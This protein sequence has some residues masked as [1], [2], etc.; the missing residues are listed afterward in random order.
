MSLGFLSFV[1]SSSDVV[2]SHGASST[3]LFIEVSFVSE[4]IIGF[5][6]LE[7]LRAEF[8]Q[9]LLSQSLI[10]TVKDVRGDT[11]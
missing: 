10:G 1:L 4:L 11:Q 9:F 7:A 5:L 3:R 6:G 2:S 8:M